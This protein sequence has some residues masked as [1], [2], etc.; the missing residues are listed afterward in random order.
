[1]PP[2]SILVGGYIRDII[3]RRLKNKIDIDIVVPTNSIEIGKK[4]AENCNGKFIILDKE[5]DVVRVIFQHIEILHAPA[6]S[7]FICYFVSN[8]FSRIEI[9][10]FV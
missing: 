1:M 8:K 10:K 7:I 5:R 9:S 6:R 4:I 3:L 2:G